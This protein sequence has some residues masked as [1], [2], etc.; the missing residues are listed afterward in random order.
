[1]HSIGHGTHQFVGCWAAVP[2]TLGGAFGARKCVVN[3]WLRCKVNSQGGYQP[4]ADLGPSCRVARVTA[5]LIRA[6]RDVSFWDPHRT[7][8]IICLSSGLSATVGP[9]PKYQSLVARVSARR[10]SGF[11]RLGRLALCTSLRRERSKIRG[12]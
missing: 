9:R 12:D 11:N 2:G 8:G 6:W 5:D 3:Y 7:S 4:T 10:E 1:M